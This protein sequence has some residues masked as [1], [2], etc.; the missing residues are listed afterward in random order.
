MKIKVSP[1]KPLAPLNE[2]FPQG[3]PVYEDLG[4]IEINGNP[5]Y[6]FNADAV[7]ETTLRKILA[8]ATSDDVPFVIS[9]ILLSQHDLMIPKEWTVCI[10]ELSTTES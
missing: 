6:L 2:L 3:I 8:I 5:A 10:D 1:E 4:E 9:A 7:E